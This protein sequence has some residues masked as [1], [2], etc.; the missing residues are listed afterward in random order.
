MK[1]KFNFIIIIII[2]FSVISNSQQKS[3]YWHGLLEIANQHM[4][5]GNYQDA[6][7]TYRQILERAPEVP[8]I[9]NNIGIAYQK[10]GDNNNAFENF[11]KAI[12]L[13]PDFAEALNN[14]AILYIQ[15]NMNIDIALSYAIKAL[16]INE[17][18]EFYATAGDI[19]AKKN[20]PE[21]AV[22]YYQKAVNLKKDYYNP[23]LKIA[24]IY[25]NTGRYDRALE[26]ITFLKN[27]SFRDIEVFLV[28]IN[29]LKKINR[30][31]DSHVALTELIRE[32]NTLSFSAEEEAKL[33]DE[34]VS[35]FRTTVWT[36]ALNYYRITNPGTE[37]Y[38][39][40]LIKPYT[41]VFYDFDIPFSDVDGVPFQINRNF[42]VESQKYGIN[43]NIF[44]FVNYFSVTMREVFNQI[45][46]NNRELIS[47]ALERYLLTNDKIAEAV[48]I[49]E[50]RQFI[51]GEIS[52]PE[53]GEYYIQNGE[54]YCTKHGKLH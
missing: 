36:A 14:I 39:I 8:E 23:Y 28:E 30:F 34:I 13:K 29:L 21:K 15:L 6:V 32:F 54:V 51:P 43:P 48:S 37:N 52:C 46:K 7:I 12:D 22:E 2:L 53:K 4:I 38:D 49:E 20:I 9:Y 26:H 25:V 27:E 42:Y 1:T 41:K 50:I 47:L 3:D 24:K 35:Y 33:K 17:K 18:P 40:N 10:V 45:C 11:R 44:E 31:A 19:F 5:H 16:S